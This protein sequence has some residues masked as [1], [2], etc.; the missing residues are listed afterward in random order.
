MSVTYKFATEQ[1]DAAAKAAD[2][3][4]LDNVRERALR[5]ETAWRQMAD[6][7]LKTEESRRKREEAAAAARLEA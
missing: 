7:A 1:A 4:A 3:A 6:Q 5:S 2:E